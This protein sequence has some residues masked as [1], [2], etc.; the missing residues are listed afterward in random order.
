M[1]SSR[2]EIVVGFV[3]M[4]ELAVGKCR[5][6][7]STQDL[8]G[9]YRGNFLA[10]VGASEL[11]RHAAWRQGGP[12]NHGSDRG[13]DVMLCLPL[14]IVGQRAVARPGHG[15]A[16]LLHDGTNARLDARRRG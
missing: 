7:G 14:Y 2:G 6:D 11:D 3:G 13:Q 12:R 8:G 4:S 1:R 5:L 15:P 10:T 16:E 9:D